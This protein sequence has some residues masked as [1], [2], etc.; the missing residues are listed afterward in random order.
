MT[1]PRAL[2]WPDMATPRLGAEVSGAAGWY[3][4]LLGGVYLVEGAAHRR[5]EPS[6]AAVLAYLAIQGRTHKYRIAGWLWPDAGE[7][8]ARAN[9]RQLL[10]RVR[11]QL[12]PDFIVGEGEIALNPAVRVD[13]LELQAL[14]EAAEYSRSLEYRGELLENLSFDDAPDLHEWLESERERVLQLRL[15]GAL[16]A[17]EGAREAGQLAD[18]LLHAHHALHLEPVS[19]EAHRLVMRLNHQMGDRGAAL[20]AYQ[21]CCTLLRERLATDPLPE[22]QALAERIRRVQ[23]APLPAPPEPPGPAPLLA[24]REALLARLEQAAARSR[25]LFLSGPSGIG[26]TTLASAFAR[27]RGPFLLFQARPGDRR[28]PYATAARISRDL[29][30]ARPGLA[31]RLPRWVRAELGR[32]LPAAFPDGSEAQAAPTDQLRFFGALAYL[33]DEATRDLACCVLD[34][35]QYADDAT[36]EFAAYYFQRGNFQRE[37]FQG[38]PGAGRGPLWIEVLREGDL[39]DANRAAV[40]RLL[41]PQ[42]GE[43]IE[44]PP[45][46]LAEVEAWLDQSGAPARLRAQAPTLH[47][48]SGGHPL[49][50]REVLAHLT[51]QQLGAADLARQPPPRLLTLLE[52]RFARLSPAAL[53]LARLA[54]VL[55]DRAGLPLLAQALDLSAASLTAA[56]EELRRAA[57]FSEDGS[58]HD[59]L[60]EGLLRSTPQALLCLLHGQAAQALAQTDAPA[61]EVA[62]HHLAADQPRQAAAATLR[63]ARQMLDLGEYAR[64]ARLHEEAAQLYEQQLE[65][66][67]A[68]AARAA[69]FQY[70]GN[71][72]TVPVEEASV[73]VEQLTRDALTE[74]QHSEAAQ[75][76]A[77]LAVAQGEPPERVSALVA[78]AKRREAGEAPGPSLLRLLDVELVAYSFAGRQE[79]ARQ[80]AL[81]AQRLTQG[82]AP[83]AALASLRHDIGDAL[84]SAQHPDDTEAGL[85]QLRA[86]AE[87]FAQLGE[88]YGHISAQTTLALHLERLGQALEARQLR[89]RIQTPVRAPGRVSRLDLYNRI[90]LAVNFLHRHEYLAC[91]E[92]LECLR[93]RD[94]QVEQEGVYQ[95]ALADFFYVMHDL[96]ACE[97]AVRQA[98][99]APTPHDSA[100]HVPLLRR[101]QV[102]LLRGDTAGARA[103]LDEL[104]Q[105]L[106]QRP[107][108]SYSRALLQLTQAAAPWTPPDEALALAESALHSAQRQRHAPLLA[109][110]R[111]VLA[112]LYLRAGHTAL[113]L[114][115]ARAAA[116]LSLAEPP[117]D[118]PALPWAL[119][120]ELAQARPGVWT[121]AH[122]QQAQRWL[123]RLTSPANVPERFRDGLRQQPSVQ[124]LLT[125]LGEPTG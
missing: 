125:R 104:E 50:L 58:I 23:A 95:R 100:A 105:D 94:P 42:G 106:Q 115:N 62:G 27:Q 14:I 102:L 67:L 114:E 81:E 87:M 28:I 101:G 90:R 96:D 75:A 20:A 39:D 16:R 83:S 48:Y 31:E 5:I 64:T 26:K 45:L 54:A 91:W 69:F 89:Q 29:L 121:A 44:V 9:M 18:A 43:L 88:R 7:T 57:I 22:T 84:L 56:W 6:M 40:Q 46:E 85:W 108:L 13:L 52:A 33:S 71:C 73:L 119:L 123:E 116:Q 78:G 103:A 32:L 98:L 80:L 117:R 109:Q 35:A 61:L 41:S 37:E 17:A 111:A 12:A 68:F 70:L 55:D 113:A 21:R 10:R 19:E 99:A 24:G 15:R 60:R 107:H 51:E 118:D 92:L 124:V 4:K 112:Q 66:D 93:G 82:A 86:S 8:A 2:H 120:S 3:L 76:R 36:G 47:A 77:V 110:G 63:A 49:Y 1:T 72:Q 11:L 97:V 34:D 53:N 59:L 25:L 30:H 79:E 122:Q 65:F 74:R 38:G